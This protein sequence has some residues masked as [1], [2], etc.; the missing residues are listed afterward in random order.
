MNKRD[1]NIIRS[2]NNSHMH[3][4]NDAYKTTSA[5]KKDAWN[6]CE[7]LMYRHKGHGLKILGASTY[8]FSAGFMFEDEGKPKLMYITHVNNR[9]IS[10]S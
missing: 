9:A 1:E 8:A 7:S 2:Y 10:V 3:C 5:A 6:Y 4:L